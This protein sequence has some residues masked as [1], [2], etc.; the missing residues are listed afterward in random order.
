M[1]DRRAWQWIV[2]LSGTALIVTTTLLPN[3]FTNSGP[4]PARWCIRC[5][6]LWLSD[7]ISNCAL[8]VPF[9]I[10][11][12]LIGRRPA[13]ALFLSFVF[14]AF[15]EFSQSM[16]FPPARSAAISDVIANSAGGIGGALLVHYWRTLWQP[17]PRY[18]TVLAFAWAITG[19]AV[20][21]GTSFLLTPHVDATTAPVTYQAS[22]F[23]HTPGMGWY[24]DIN[25]SAVVN[26]YRVTRGWTGPNI[27][28]ASRNMDSMSIRAYVHGRD[29][30][31][32][33]VPIVYVHVGADTSPI[34]LVGQ[35]NAAA[36]LRVTRRAWDFG[37]NFPSLRLT[38]AFANRTNGDGVPLELRATATRSRLVLESISPDGE[39]S[40]ELRL[41]PA[42]GWTLIQT[43]IRSGSL[44]APVGALSWLLFWAVPVG[45]W[46]GGG[47]NHRWATL[48][49]AALVLQAGALAGTLVFHVS[50]VSALHLAFINSSLVAA[51][52][53]RRRLSLVDSLQKR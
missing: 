16:G 33:L 1:S 26:G 9:G 50:G 46:A 32:V 13:H 34:I 20:F 39:A 31:T 11:L 35:H 18:N 37:L 14:S 28:S 4:L 21:F 40:A 24:E 51:G 5:G 7:V 48:V 22:P 6:D 8:F 30:A 52:L 36:E 42:L 27:V 12:A 17:A 15:I 38:G 19:A 2:F 45:W 29:P 44:L 3:A 23:P 10:G 41:T 43:V 25:D 47:S 49:L 53:I